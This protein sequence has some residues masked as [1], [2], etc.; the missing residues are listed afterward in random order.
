MVKKTRTEF[1]FLLSNKTLGDVLMVKVHQT[2]HCF[3]QM[4]ADHLLKLA[5]FTTSQ[6]LHK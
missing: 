2:R 6:S 4:Y 1:Q 3:E 5:K